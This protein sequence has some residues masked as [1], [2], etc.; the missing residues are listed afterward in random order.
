MKNTTVLGA[1]DEYVQQSKEYGRKDAL[2]A[3]ILYVV[4]N[5]LS[6]LMGK[7]FVQK[8]LTLTET[9]VFCVTG[10]VSLVCIGL[11][12]LFCLI[13]KQ[14]LVTVG[15]SK[16]QIKKSFILGMILFILVAIVGGI[17]S[18]IS[19]STIQT[20]SGVIFMRVIY[21]FIFIG[22][23]E[24]LVF[25]GYIGTRLYG[26]FTNKRLSFVIVGIM[27]SLLHIPFH[28]VVAQVS[29]S[30][31][32]S[33]NLVSLIYIFLLHYVFQWLYSKYNSIVAP[34]ILHFIW[35]FILWFII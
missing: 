27:F 17:W 18:I 32:I 31:Y 16:N 14:K 33:V 12:F 2:L 11:V 8:G 25:R 29:L 7:I 13:R 34:T 19:G 23:M 5:L 1:D 9:F 15:F 26:C 21:F 20:N 4:M 6:V 3:L 24:E 28:M 10:I 30:E 35:N 22:F